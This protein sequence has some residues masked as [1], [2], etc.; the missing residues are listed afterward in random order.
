MLRRRPVGVLQCTRKAPTCSIASR[1]YGSADGRSQS[2]PIQQQHVLPTDKCYTL[3]SY[4]KIHTHADSGRVNYMNLFLLLLLVCCCTVIHNKTVSAA[5]RS[6]ASR[7]QTGTLQ[8][9]TCGPLALRD[10]G[11]CMLPHSTLLR[12]AI[13]HFCKAR[14]CI[15]ERALSGEMLFTPFLLL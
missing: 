14:G 1:K 3:K 8:T 4:T 15:A 10:G 7:V 13:I 9:S 5:C 6:N 11:A 2:S 12:M